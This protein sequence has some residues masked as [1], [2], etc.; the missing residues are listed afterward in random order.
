MTISYSR[1]IC[2]FLDLAVHFCYHNI[3]NKLR[4]F[5]WGDNEKI[6]L[7]DVASVYIYEKTPFDIGHSKLSGDVLKE[8]RC[9]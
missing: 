2:F 6:L 8:R 4:I 7:R 9:L 3:I 1:H 5:P